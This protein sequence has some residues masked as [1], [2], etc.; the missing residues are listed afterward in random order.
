MA[1]LMTAPEAMRD[2]DERVAG[3]I[4][5]YLAEN[6]GMRGEFAERIA[7]QDEIDR[8]LAAGEKIPAEW[9]ENPFHQRYYA[10]LGRLEERP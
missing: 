2:A 3:E 5:R 1:G 4:A 6:P 7:R 10:H 9:I 8:R